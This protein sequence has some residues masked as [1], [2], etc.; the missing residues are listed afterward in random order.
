M[1]QAS[2]LLPT[3]AVRPD[4]LGP[5][6]R[7]PRPQDQSYRHCQNAAIVPEGIWLPSI[8]CTLATQGTSRWNCAKYDIGVTAIGMPASAS[9]STTLSLRLLS[10]QEQMFTFGLN[11]RAPFSRIVRKDG[12]MQFVSEHP[13]QANSPPS[14][15]VPHAAG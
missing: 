11:G 3:K 1:T 10:Q 7:K 6:D 4:S 13:K 8:F 14:A 5:K 2:T 15:A 9:R 12:Q